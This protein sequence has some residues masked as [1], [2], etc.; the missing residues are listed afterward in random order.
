MYP[1]SKL[2]IM[3]VRDT[4]LNCYTPDPSGSKD[5]F[6]SKLDFF[7]VKLKDEWYYLYVNHHLLPDKFWKCDQLNGLIK[8]MRKYL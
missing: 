1:K 5:T 6:F 2:D 3:N 7:I 8:C 4:S